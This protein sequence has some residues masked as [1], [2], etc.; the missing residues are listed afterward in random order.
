MTSVFKIS[1]IPAYKIRFTN[2]KF[3]TR[4][5]TYNSVKKETNTKVLSNSCGYLQ[6]FEHHLV[7]F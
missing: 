4:F 5:Y 6:L 7:T 2:C 3:F 1:Q